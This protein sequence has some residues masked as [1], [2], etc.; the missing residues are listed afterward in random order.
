[1]KDWSN[2]LEIKLSQFYSSG[3]LKHFKN[4]ISNYQRVE[5][6][7]TQ[8]SDYLNEIEK[9]LNEI[10]SVDVNNEISDAKSTELSDNYRKKGNDCYSKKDN[11]N[12]FKFYTLAILY[13]QNS[14]NSLILGYSNR[15]AVFFDQKLFEQC[16]LDLNNLKTLLL[17]SSIANQTENSSLVLKLLS[18]EVNSLIELQRSAIDLDQNEFVKILRIYSLENVELNTK[19]DHLKRLIRE[20]CPNRETK[21]LD[22]HKYEEV[23]NFICDSI[24][25]K[26]AESKG[27]HCI[28]NR[29]INPGECLF[30]EKA[31]CAIILPEFNLNYCQLCFKRIYDETSDRFFSLNIQ[32]CDKCASVLYCSIECKNRAESSQDERESFHRYECGILKRLLHNLGIAHLSYRILISTND[33]KLLEF[34]KYEMN[35]EII[36]LD[37]IKTN[38]KMADNDYEQIFNLLTHEKETHVDDLFKYSITSILLGKHFLNVSFHINLVMHWLVGI[39]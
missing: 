3:K 4:L 5:F 17:A 37:Q 20:K 33:D 6:I 14:S 9:F 19:I 35:N 10:Y 2:F 27:R 28:A 36:S 12:A 7:I 30:V 21:S 18:R 39:L 24:D 13:A 32:P 11:S 15:S 34:S 25:V 38:Y 8:S 22:T 23:S 16:L 29:D 31:Y 26:Y 1:M